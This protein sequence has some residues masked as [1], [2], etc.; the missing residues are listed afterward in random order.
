M[1]NFDLDTSNFSRTVI[2]ALCFEDTC[3]TLGC[4][5]VT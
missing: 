3:G 1:L 4:I 5:M 2:F